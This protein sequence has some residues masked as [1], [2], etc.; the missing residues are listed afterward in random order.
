HG[1]AA[2]TLRTH[3]VVS[4]PDLTGLELRTAWPGEAVVRDA[5]QSGRTTVVRTTGLLDARSRCGAGAGGFAAVGARAGFVASFLVAG[6]VFAAAGRF[7][8]CGRRAG[9]GAAR[10]ARRAG[11]GSRP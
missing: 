7:R 11:A 1:H 8:S 6:A 2:S 3:R 9:S 4:A 10:S 5:R